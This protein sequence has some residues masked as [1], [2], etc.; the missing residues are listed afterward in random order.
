MPSPRTV[1][2]RPVRAQAIGHQQGQQAVQPHQASLFTSLT[3]GVVSQEEGNEQVL[4]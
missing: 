1:I 4:G 3:L 2:P